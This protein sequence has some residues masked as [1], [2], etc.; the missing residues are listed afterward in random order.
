[1]VTGGEAFVK[2]IAD[3]MHTVKYKTSG[4]SKTLQELEKAGKA[5]GSSLEAL[6]ARI[7]EAIDLSRETTTSAVPSS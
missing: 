1:M 5:S 6:Y 2:H 3:H 4:G 7:K